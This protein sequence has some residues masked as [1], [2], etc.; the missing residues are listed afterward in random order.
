MKK[1][2]F[3]QAELIKYSFDLI[4]KEGWSS[5]S[6][7]K[8]SKSLNTELNI[9]KDLLK[10]KKQLLIIFSEYIDEEVMKNVDINDLKDNSVRDNLFELLML[11]FE[12]L[13]PFK[14]SLRILLND[15]KSKPRDLKEIYKKI[16]NSLDFYMEISNSKKNFIFDLIKLN[17]IFLIYSLTFKTWLND[18]SKDMSITMAELD[19]WLSKAEHY[20]E[21]ISLF[22]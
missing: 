17:S 2:T 9:V 1:K 16:I 10:S 12:K 4:E 22:H 11:R 3:S 15:L 5:F 6:F 7:N 13:Q 14:T 18:E 21:K 8:L 19:K 20:S